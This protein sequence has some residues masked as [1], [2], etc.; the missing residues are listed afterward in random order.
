MNFFF[1]MFVSI[2]LLMPVMT[3]AQIYSDDYSLMYEEESALFDKA[4]SSNPFDDI[5]SDP[6][7]IQ[8]IDGSFKQTVRQLENS[9]KL[10]HDTAVGRIKLTSN[11]PIIE[12]PYELLLC[13][14]FIFLVYTAVRILRALFRK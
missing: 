2:A 8:D 14:L 13:F 9:S 1:L 4:N 12:F 7:I 11:D 3:K 6:G 10:C 5:L